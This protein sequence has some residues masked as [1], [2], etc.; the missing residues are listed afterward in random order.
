MEVS[1]QLHPQAALP[2]THW[3]GGWLEPRVCLDAVAKKK[4]NSF[5]APAG[6]QSV[7]VQPIA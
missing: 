3:I 2:D 6:N 5:I 4:K 7:V 1:G